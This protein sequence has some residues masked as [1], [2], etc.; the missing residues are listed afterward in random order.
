MDLIMTNVSTKAELN[1]GK[2]SM[3]LKMFMAHD[4][5]LRKRLKG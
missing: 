4:D 5:F 2:L 1:L 3:V